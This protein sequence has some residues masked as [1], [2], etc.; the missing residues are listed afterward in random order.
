MRHPTL[1][2]ALASLFLLTSA[3]DRSGRKADSPEPGGVEPAPASATGS[4]GGTTQDGED[5]MSFE[6]KSSA[7]GDHEEIPTKYTCEGD[8][9][10]F[11]LSWSGAPDTTK[12]FVLTVYDP[13][14]PDPDNPKQ[15][16]I[17]WVLYD[18]PAGT[19]SLGAAL[20]PSDL[21]KGTRQGTNSWKRTG[22]GGP[23]PPIGRHR[24]FTVVYALD[25]TFGD[26][27]DEPT[28][29]ELLKAIDGHVLGKGEL[30]GTYQKKKGS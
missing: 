3:C 10:S 28:R 19:T 17:H 15:T 16:W 5:P 30:V 23:C 18:I 4:T 12:S 13:D 8:D 11:P 24:Y 27:L 21:P 29:D 25:K 14:A 9:V 1:I 6:L 20:K 7:F 26:S 2:A 22:W